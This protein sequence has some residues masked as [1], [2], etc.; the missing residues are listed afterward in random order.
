MP[1]NKSISIL[2]YMHLGGH[3]STYLSIGR[4]NLNNF[5]KIY[6]QKGFWSKHRWYNDELDYQKYFKIIHTFFLK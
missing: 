6:K 5:S 3:R 2:I 4:F 1:I